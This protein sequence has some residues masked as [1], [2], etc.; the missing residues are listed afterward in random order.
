MYIE[1]K[2]DIIILVL[3]YILIDNQYIFD[4]FIKNFDNI[5]NIQSQYRVLNKNYPTFELIFFL[6]KMKLDIPKPLL[7]NKILL[8]TIS[9]TKKILLE[10]NSYIINIKMSKYC[11][12]YIIV[13]ILKLK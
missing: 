4:R 12:L 13:Y 5:Y 8:Y 2:V 6:A 11:I 3:D 1:V 9:I 7:Y 10:K